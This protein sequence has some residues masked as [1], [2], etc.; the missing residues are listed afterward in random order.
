MLSFLYKVY[1]YLACTG[2]A[3]ILFG[4]VI[5]MIPY[6]DRNGERY[7]MLNH[8]ISELGEKG[9]SKNAWGFNT[10]MFLGGWLFLPLIVILGIKLSSIPGWIG[11]TFGVVACVAASLVGVFS[12]DHLTR[13]RRA[14]MTFFHSG[15]WCIVFFTIAVF[16]QPAGLRVIPLAVNFVGLLAIASFSAFLMVVYSKPDPNHTS[17]YILDPN[18]LPNRPRVWRT[19]IL[20]WCI[21]FTIQAWFVAAAILSITG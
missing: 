11:T 6:R 8:F 9:I 21:F 4:V 20:E 19:A 14:A 18:A 2:T 10:G 5:S 13:H 7:S 12:M 3:L 1:P 16:I 17:N 15:L